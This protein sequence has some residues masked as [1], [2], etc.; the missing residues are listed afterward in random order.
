MDVNN[1]SYGLFMFRGTQ[2]W[3]NIKDVPIFIKRVFFVLKHGYSPAAK[4]DTFQ[5]F[6]AVMKEILVAYRNDRFGDAIIIDDYFDSEDNHEV[7]HKENN[8]IFDNM[9]N[10]LD[11]MDE[12]NPIYESMNWKEEERAKE[13]AKNEFFKL[14]SEHFY[15]LWD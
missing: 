8:R 15:E 14:F 12:H 13:N 2:F 10:L 9:L 7:N 1:I 3:R 5:W 4:W 6:I 11:K